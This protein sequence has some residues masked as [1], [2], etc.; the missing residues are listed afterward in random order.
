[1]CR[2]LPSVVIPM[3]ARLVMSDERQQQAVGRTRWAGVTLGV[4]LGIVFEMVAVDNNISWGPRIH[5]P[6][7]IAYHQQ[8]VASSVGHTPVNLSRDESAACN[9]VLSTFLS[10][11]PI[12]HLSSL[13]VCCTPALDTPIAFEV[14]VRAVND[15][16][17][18]DFH[19]VQPTL[20][21]DPRNQS[22]FMLHP[23]IDG[24]AM[25]TY[26]V[27]GS[28]V[29]TECCV[30]VT[31]ANIEEQKTLAVRGDC[32]NVMRMTDILAANLQVSTSDH[33]PASFDT[34]STSASAPPLSSFTVLPW[35]PT[36]YSLVSCHRWCRVMF[37]LC[38]P[39][40]R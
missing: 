33:S 10:L 36:R 19:V 29:L 11:C 24:R 17:L 26:T 21:F 38:H 34:V 3:S 16:Q 39:R 5:P 15:M 9:S 27:A 2:L 31:L 37:L 12:A 25:A 4:S 8:R 20:R 14:E 13:T 22:C 40:T 30:D 6:N 18:R 28:G 1:M 35:N 7:V 32:L 23:L